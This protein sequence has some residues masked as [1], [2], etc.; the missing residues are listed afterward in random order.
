MSQAPAGQQAD[1]DVAPITDIDFDAMHVSPDG[2][3]LIGTRCD[4]CSTLSFPKRA[5]CF[6]C[7]SRTLTA[8]LLAPAGSLYSYSTVHIS[9]SRPVPYTIGY[10]DLNDGVRL[11]A[12]VVN[13]GE[14]Q[15]DM[16]MALRVTD[17]GFA[18]CPSATG[19]AA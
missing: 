7:G 8:E 13:D 12:N 2:T 3:R 1:A 15:L 4:V 17:A 19:A 10:I 14:L 5:V 9:S 6:H 18:F 11:L 16:P